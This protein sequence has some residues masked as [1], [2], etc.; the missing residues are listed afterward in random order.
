MITLEEELSRLNRR[1]D[2][3]EAGI[4]GFHKRLFYVE[5]EIAN[6][7]EKEQG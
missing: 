2:V 3:I 6:H 4:A 7:I 5:N 1:L